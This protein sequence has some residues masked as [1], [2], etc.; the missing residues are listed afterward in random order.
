M[1]FLI[2]NLSLFVILAPT[3][4]Q[5]TK[6]PTLIRV[7]SNAEAIYPSVKPAPKGIRKETRLCQAKMKHLLFRA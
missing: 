4:K 6:K 2:V 5:N 1:I 7:D 3:E